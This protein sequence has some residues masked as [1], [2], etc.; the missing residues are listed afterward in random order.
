VL[1]DLSKSFYNNI[2][3]AVNEKNL[4]DLKNYSHLLLELI[5]DI[6]KILG[7][8]ENY[9]LSSWVKRRIHLFRKIRRT[10]ETENG[11]KFSSSNNFMGRA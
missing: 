7:M 2:V 10:N 3:L 6:D 9:M 4:G 1:G 11:S 8:N 5:L